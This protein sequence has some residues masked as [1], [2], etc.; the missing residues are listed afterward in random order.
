MNNGIVSVGANQTF[1]GHTYN[2][3]LSYRPTDLKKYFGIE[4][5]WPEDWSALHLG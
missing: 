5:G 2:R 3:Y 1:G 4:M